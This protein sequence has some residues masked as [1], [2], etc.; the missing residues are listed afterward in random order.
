MR[1]EL[2]HLLAELIRLAVRVKKGPLVLRGLFF[3]DARSGRQ[4]PSACVSDVIQR[5]VFSSCVTIAW[6]HVEDTSLM[7]C[8]LLSRSMD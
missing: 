7:A 4:T 1:P 8:N 5:G 3:A 6:I 2:R